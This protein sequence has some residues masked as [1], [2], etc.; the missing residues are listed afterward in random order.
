MAYSAGEVCVRINQLVVEIYA[1]SQA[2]INRKSDILGSDIAVYLPA[3]SCL[4]LN[5]ESAAKQENS[6]PHLIFKWIHLDGI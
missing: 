2:D 1:L 3:S 4:K 5:F 6:F